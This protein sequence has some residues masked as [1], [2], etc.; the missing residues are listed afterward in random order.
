M[1]VAPPKRL[2][3]I[4]CALEGASTPQDL[5]VAIIEFRDFFR[6]AH[7]S[8]RWISA[9]GA[10]FDLSTFPTHWTNRYVEKDY[11]RIDPVVQGCQQRFHP[12]D[13]RRL[14]W[15]G[16][17]VRAFAQDARDHGIG[18]QGY[19]VPL[20]GPNGQF[21]LFTASHDCDDA[22][23]AHFTATYRRK[24]FLIAHYFNDKAMELAADPAQAATRALSPREADAL[25]LLALGYG[26]AQVAKTLSISEHTLRVYI[27]SAR[28]KLG[29]LNTV[30]AVARALSQGRI[31][32]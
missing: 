16:K 26:R 13:W 27:E 18:H 4:L 14:D 7:L 11:L 24:L 20:R 32:I 30:H 2:E 10:P 23:W 31:A 5:Q 3:T 22:A 12:V 19:S 6:V 28:A 9:G 1:N 15:S 21:A 25:T 8:Y 29:A 17:A